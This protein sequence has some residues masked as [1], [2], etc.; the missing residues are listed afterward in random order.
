[1]PDRLHFT[2]SDEAN[3]LLASDPMALLIGFALDQQVS[4]QKAFAGPLT[5]R[6][7]LGTIDVAT[8]ADSDLEPVFRAKP[9]IHR[10]P[11]AMAERVHALAVHIR[12]EY[13]GDASR[14]WT[15]AA[16]ADALRANLSALPG[17]GEM[18]IKALG[19]VLSKRFGIRAADGLVP[20]HPTLGDVDSPQAL[21]DYQAA[22]RAH[23]AQWSR[24]QAPAAS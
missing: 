23:K 1:M 10:F 13:D 12:D 15:D 6:E 19:A 5:L 21:A 14:V 4:V 3:A 17:F 20:W 7:R 9:A 22:K 2:E 24:G 18:K 8:L 16:D 11:G